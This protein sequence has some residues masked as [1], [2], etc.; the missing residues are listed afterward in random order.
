MLYNQDWDNSQEL[1]PFTMPHFIA[2]LEQHPPER[3]YKWHECCGTCLLSQYA[4]SITGRIE[5]AGSIAYHVAAHMG[6]RVGDTFAGVASAYL[7]PH[8]FGAALKR[9]KA[10]AEQTV[11]A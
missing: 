3:T 6:P 7:E 1:K 10:Y 4:G 2:W 9:A 11:P 5:D 8:T